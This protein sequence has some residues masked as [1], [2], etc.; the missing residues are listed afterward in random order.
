VRNGVKGGLSE[1]VG[2]CALLALGCES[3]ELKLPKVRYSTEHLRIHTD[4]TACAGNADRLERHVQRLEDV[5]ETRVEKPIDVYWVRDNPPC[6]NDHAGGCYYPDSRTVVTEYWAARHE[7][8]HAISFLW[9]NP[10]RFYGEGVAQAFSGERT[11]FGWSLP[12]ASLGLM[13]HVPTGDAA[14]FMRWLYE[15][16]GVAPLR[17]L[18][19]KSRPGD[20]SR[21]EQAFISA[22]GVSIQQ[23]EQTY[24]AAAPEFYPGLSW[25]FDDVE[26]LPWQG[27][28]WQHSVELDCEQ[29]HTRGIDTMTRTLAFEVQREQDFTFEIEA[30]ASAYLTT[31]QTEVVEKGGQDVPESGVVGEEP[32]SSFYSLGEWIE[33]GGPVELYLFPG[34]YRLTIEV[35]VVGRIAVRVILAPLLTETATA[36][37]ADEPAQ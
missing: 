19:E 36:L 11:G 3:D 23:M 6:G 2:L 37:G 1:A 35:P 7:L 17:V 30:P 27:E 34:R 29:T 15:Q 4:F 33:S 16:Y 14:H 18:F 25:C 8:G 26:V 22:Y 31:C 9:G 21:A 20:R 13:P 24:Y 12:S 28:F 32:G 10:E 5:L